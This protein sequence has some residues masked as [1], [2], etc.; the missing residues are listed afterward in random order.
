[1]PWTRL[2]CEVSYH[3]A[4]LAYRSTGRKNPVAADDK[5]ASW[6]KFQ[7]MLHFGLV[8]IETAS[9]HV[10]WSSLLHYICQEDT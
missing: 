7:I 5:G 4:L 2:R 3:A 6:E 10:D 9:P 1:M 8:L